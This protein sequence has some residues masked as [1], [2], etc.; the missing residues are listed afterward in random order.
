MNKKIFYPVQNMTLICFVFAITLIFSSCKTVPNK[1]EAPK[2]EKI[3]NVGKLKLKTPPLNSKNTTGN[4]ASYSD[5][6]II[7][8]EILPKHTTM[9]HEIKSWENVYE[10]KQHEIFNNNHNKLIKLIKDPDKIEKFGVNFDATTI[11]EVVEIFRTILNF[12]YIIDPSVKGAVTCKINET[13]MARKDILKLFEHI[14]WLSGSYANV[15]NGIMNIMPLTSMAKD[16]HA[17]HDPEANVVVTFVP[18]HFAKSGNIIK[19]LQPFMTTGSTVTDLADQNTLLI[20]ESPENMPKITDLIKAL[21]NPGE[22][23]WPHIILTCQFTDAEVVVDELKDLLPVLGFP[24]TDKASTG[25]QI[26]MTVLPRQ[27]VIV[28]S[29]ALSAV[30]QEVERWHKVLDS[31]DSAEEENIFVYNVK[32]SDTESLTALLNTFFNASTSSSPI[33]N[34]N[35]TSSRADKRFPGRT[36]GLRRGTSGLRGK[37]TKRRSRT[38]TNS[39]KEGDTIF[40]TSVIIYASE[41]YN[42]LTIR[43]TNRAYALIKALLQRHDIPVKQVSIEAVIA[44]ITLT[45]STEFGFAYALEHKD[46]QTGVD[47]TRGKVSWTDSGSHWGSKGS[48]MGLYP[49]NP[50]LGAG[51]GIA[52]GILKG[53]KIMFLKAVA[54]KGNV[55]VVSRPSLMAKTGKTASISYGQRVPIKTGSYTNTA[56]AGSSHDSYQYQDTGIK[57]DVEPI[58]TAGNMVNLKVSIDISDVVETKIGLTDQ[59]SFSTNKIES[60]LVVADNGTV[61]MGGLISTKITDSHS[62]IPVLKDIPYL[63]KIFRSNYKRKDRSEMLIMITVRIIDDENSLK[64]LLERYKAALKSIKEQE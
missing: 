49:A 14:L 17:F 19:N 45:K 6:P 18:I 8:N 51:G 7:V 54:G 50:A 25:G 46:W 2:A 27:Q 60:E 48:V 1:T 23:A 9:E 41:S 21:D 22:A 13:P 16:P 52:A 3:T 58:I 31:S 35:S 15:D 63:G 38:T 43:T 20:V 44:D 57:L 53:D 34:S 59:P 12:G 28:V 4:N 11:P 62:G 55:K 56:S 30:L 47:F 29:A 39:N 10:R 24:V 33:S 61:M 36:G 32:H 64:T 26:K 5:K 37:T 42:R 40:D